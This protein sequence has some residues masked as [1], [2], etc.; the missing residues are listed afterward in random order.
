MRDHVLTAEFNKDWLVFPTSLMP[1]GSKYRSI[2]PPHHLKSESQRD[3][4][5]KSPMKRRRNKGQEWKGTQQRKD[6]EFTPLQKKWWRKVT[7]ECRW[8]GQRT[9]YQGNIA[10][11]HKMNYK[12]SFIWLNCLL[13]NIQQWSLDSVKCMAEALQHG[14]RWGV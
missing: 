8:F 4:Y 10:T 2:P 13:G 14:Q 5:I 12:L 6:R 9:T 11:S 7:E 3:Y 1:P